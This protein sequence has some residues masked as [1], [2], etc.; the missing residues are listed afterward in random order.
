MG[1]GSS[2][3][4][5]REMSDLREEIERIAVLEVKYRGSFGP[6][7]LERT[8]ANFQ[9]IKQFDSQIPC[10]YVTVIETRGY[11]WAVYRKNLGFPA[12][13]LYWWSNKRKVYT[14]SRDWDNLVSRLASIVK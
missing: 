5:R 7:A 6:D 4:K 8:R 10:F 9:R 14:E 13:T 11:K 12:Y 3:G 2:E 1:W